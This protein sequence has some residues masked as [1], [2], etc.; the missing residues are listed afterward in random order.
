MI[1]RPP[2]KPPAPHPVLTRLNREDHAELCE[3]CEL[4]GQSRYH[5]IQKWIKYGLEIER[6]ELNKRKGKGKRK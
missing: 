5:F 2:L 4:T 1:N 3:I 6:K